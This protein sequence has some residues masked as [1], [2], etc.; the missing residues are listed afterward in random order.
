LYTNTISPANITN[1]ENRVPSADLTSS[2][3]VIGAGIQAIAVVKG[4]DPLTVFGGSASTMSIQLLSSSSDTLTDIAFTDNMPDGM[5]LA[6]PI[7]FNVGAC[8]GT[9]SGTPAES[10]FSFNG[11]TLPPFG[12]CTLTLSVTMT[13][14]GNLTNV[15]PA[16]AVTTANGVTT[17]DPAEASLTNLPGVSIS[18]FFVSNPIT[19]GSDSALT[20]TIQNTGN[21]PLSGMG[22]SDSLPAG[23]AISRASAPEPV[24]NCGG[25]LT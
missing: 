17:V 5:I 2:L 9:L 15:V 13:V 4:F 21:I 25:T 18:K 10:S 11:G 23:L 1:N 22:F 14:N 3:T 12:S 7:N 20:I 16:G 24:N 6:N 19:P 8:G